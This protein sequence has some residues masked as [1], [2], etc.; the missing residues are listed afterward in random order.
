MTSALLAVADVL[1][2]AAPTGGIV[3]GFLVFLAIAF[4]VVIGLIV[5]AVVGIVRW[6]RKRRR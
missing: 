1:A 5:L 2:D 3:I 6:R 4:V